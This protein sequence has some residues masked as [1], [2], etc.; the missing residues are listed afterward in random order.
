MNKRRIVPA[1][2][3]P[4][5]FSNGTTFSTR[6]AT[7]NC[8]LSNLSDALAVTEDEDRSI[9]NRRD[10]TIT[11]LTKSICYYPNNYSINRNYLKEIS[12]TFE[13]IFGW[14]FHWFVPSDWRCR[15]DVRRILLQWITLH[16]SFMASVGKLQ[17]RAE[18]NWINLPPYSSSP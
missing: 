5:M 1:I 9:V 17:P 15:Y 6:P 12:A 3:P 16:L 18:R 13:C 7:R 4:R 14:P 10:D 8:R 2:A 11:S